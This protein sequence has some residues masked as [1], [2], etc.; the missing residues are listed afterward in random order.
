MFTKKFKIVEI[1]NSGVVVTHY[2]K[3]KKAEV[4]KDVEAFKDISYKYEMMSKNSMI[5]WVE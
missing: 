5:I 4:K 2:L 1:R 3:G